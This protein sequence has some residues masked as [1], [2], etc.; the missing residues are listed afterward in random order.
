MQSSSKTGRKNTE[1]VVQ[2]IWLMKIILWPNSLEDFYQ[3][4]KQIKILLSDISDE[5]ESHLHDFR[6]FLNSNS[7]VTFESLV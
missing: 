5:C 6:N 2:D 1:F 4:F 3:I 7:Y